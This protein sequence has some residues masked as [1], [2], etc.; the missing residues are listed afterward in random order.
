M[1]ESGT[2]EARRPFVQSRLV[3]G[4]P[5]A[6]AVICSRYHGTSAKLAMSR[7]IPKT[8]TAAIKVAATKKSSHELR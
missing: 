1:G 6:I 7:T 8:A 5:F 3:Q 4:A 2:R